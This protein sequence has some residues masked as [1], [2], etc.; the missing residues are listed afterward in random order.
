MGVLNRLF[1][2]FRFEP[3]PLRGEITVPG[4]KSISHRALIIGAAMS[5]P[6]PVHNLNPGLDVQATQNALRALGAQIERDGTSAT[7]HP[8]RLHD[9]DVTLDCENSASTARLLLGVCAG[10]NVRARFDG[11]ESLR[12][13]PMEPVAAQLRAFGAKI[14]TQEGHLPATIAGTPQVQTRRFILLTPSAQI[15]SALILAGLYARTPI[16]ISND[17]RSRDHT[18]RLLQ[19]LGADIR[20]DGTSVQYAPSSLVAVPLR[21][22]GDLSSAAFFI[23]A[24]SISP[25]S[26]IM[27]RDVGVNPT[28][29]GLLEALQQMGARIFLSNRR[30]WN[31]EPVAD[32]AVEA[33]T[34]RGANVGAD[35][36]LRAIDEIPALAV[37]A[38]FAQGTTRISGIRQLR[39]K[40]SD[41][42]AAIE[43]LLATIG[44]SVEPSNQ[45]LEIA[46]LLQPRAPAQ[47]VVETLGDHRIAMA[48]AALAAGSGA[49]EI[50][51]AGVADASFPDFA[52]VWSAAQRQKTQP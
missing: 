5:Q 34:L 40:E 50:D 18:E 15:K 1:A 23:V 36:A 45:G 32:I 6:L 4:D 52:K 26:S 2:S 7:L 46:G 25:G 33:G 31:N 44:A 39:D 16:D 42:I 29:T 14:E 30:E 49:I 24:A 20:F 41:R 48:A 47:P 11:D 27:L 9:V 43:R 37:A 28:R 10:A 22:P 38:A 19:A 35:L 3:G 21:V 17:V 51:D 8:A 12:R 13:R